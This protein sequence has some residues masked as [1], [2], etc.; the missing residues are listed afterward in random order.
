[1]KTQ[2]IKFKDGQAETLRGGFLDLR[3]LG[4]ITVR[5]SSEIEFDEHEQMHYIR[6]LEPALEHLNDGLRN[7]FFA[8]YELAVEHEV[9][10]LNE[11]RKTT[12]F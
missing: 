12:S 8:T 10:L 7:L 4:E 1:M 5:R 6:L 9:A 11:M 2:V 3:K